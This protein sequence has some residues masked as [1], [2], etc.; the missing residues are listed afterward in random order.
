VDE[1]ETAYRNIVDLRGN[2]QLLR[3]TFIARAGHCAFSPAET[4]AAVGTLLTRVETGH[5]P[6]IEANLLNGDAAALG[7]RFNLVA[8]GST[9]VP[10][11]PAFVDTFPGLYPRPYDSLTALCE[12]HGNGGIGCGLGFGFGLLQAH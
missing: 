12:P 2:G 5:W 6:S 7:P 10:A 8:V 4:I 3:Q 9:I 11:A 1:N